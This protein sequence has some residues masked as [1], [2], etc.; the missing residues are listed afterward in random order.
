MTTQTKRGNN[1]LISE[2]FGDII[3]QIKRNKS[4]NNSDQIKNNLLNIGK[5][6]LQKPRKSR[7]EIR[8][9]YTTN[10]PSVRGPTK[11]FIPN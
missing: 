5:L 3:S 8:N 1:K 9:S 4:K 7:N 2:S 10:L 6:K 11:D